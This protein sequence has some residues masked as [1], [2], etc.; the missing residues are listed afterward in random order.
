MNIK[1]AG[2]ESR[3]AGIPILNI[4]MALNM[5]RARRKLTA[6]VHIFAEKCNLHDNDLPA[7]SV[8]PFQLRC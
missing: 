8:P 7:E 6:L 3:L 2:E 5:S 4:H 1:R